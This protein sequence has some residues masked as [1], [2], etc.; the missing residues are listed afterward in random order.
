M[1]YRDEQLSRKR[2]KDSADIICTCSHALPHTPTEA[3]RMDLC[4]HKQKNSPHLEQFPQSI[5]PEKDLFSFSKKYWVCS[6]IQLSLENAS[7]RSSSEYAVNT[8][9]H[10]QH[11]VYI[12]THM[13][14]NS[15]HT[16]HAHKMHFLLLLQLMQITTVLDKSI[17]WNKFVI[18]LKCK[19]HLNN[20]CYIY[21]YIYIYIHT[22]THTYT[23]THTHIYTVYIYIYIYIIHNYIYFC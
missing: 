15:L 16:K 13:Q 7:K 5:A 12:K 6:V 18:Y 4:T 11:A 22:H 19:V 1:T 2:Q 14:I 8:Q 10:Q 21:I 17:A 20:Y 3:M 23:N 9:T